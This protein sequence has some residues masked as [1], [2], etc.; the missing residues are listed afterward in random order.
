MSE[1][2]NLLCKTC[3]DKL[4]PMEKKDIY[5]CPSCGNEYL[6]QPDGKVKAIGDKVIIHATNVVMGGGNGQTAERAECP[7]C[8]RTNRMEDTFRCHECGRAGIC[9]KHQDEHSH[10]CSD[11]MATIRPVLQE[12]E[13]KE[14][15][16]EILERIVAGKLNRKQ[17]LRL[18]NQYYGSRYTSE[19]KQRI[20]NKFRGPM[21]RR[22]GL[23]ISIFFV[24]VVLLEITNNFSYFFGPAAFPTFYFV[25]SIIVLLSLIPLMR[26]KTQEVIKEEI[27]R[28]RK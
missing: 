2:M 20:N 1:I 9:L 26:S 11:C 14:R 3:G 7:I 19:L 15:Y 24:W 5:T 21:F 23:A 13:N 27:E 22:I 6:L 10:F 28:L 17:S 18:I 4:Q 8:G 25:P 12:K 16:L